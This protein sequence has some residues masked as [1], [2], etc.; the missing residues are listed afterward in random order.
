MCETKR[1]WIGSGVCAQYAWW[2]FLLWQFGI[3]CIK[4]ALSVANPDLSRTQWNVC[5]YCIAY[6]CTVHTHTYVY[7]Y[8]HT[9]ISLADKIAGLLDHILHALVPGFVLHL[10]QIGRHD[11]RWWN[12][13]KQWN[14]RL[15]AASSMRTSMQTKTPNHKQQSGLTGRWWQRRYREWWRIARRIVG[16]FQLL[17]WIFFHA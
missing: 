11:A 16:Y 9:P 17:L 7:I 3:R 5:M 1:T 10:P 6:N 2:T 14:G 15:G 4:V 8:I 12:A 13:M